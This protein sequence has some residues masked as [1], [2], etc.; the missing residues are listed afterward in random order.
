MLK[1]NVIANYFGQFWSA[2]MGMAFIPLY[3]KYLGIESYGLIGV[4]TMLTTWLSLLDMG[5]TPTLGREMA[6]FS[7]GA[8]NPKYLRNL[9]RSVEIISISVGIFVSI[10][11]ALSSNWIATSWL[12]S[13][14][15]PI[16]T[17]KS[18][19][20][21]MGIVSSLKFVEGIFK[22]C[23]VGLQRQVL[24][25]IIDASTSTIRGLGAV[26]ILSL[27]SPTI[28][29]FFIWQIIISILNV[30]ILS[31][32]TYSSIP[33]VNEPSRFSIEALKSIKKFAGGIVGGTFLTFFL[34]QIDKIL[35]SKLLSLQEFG[36]YTLAIGVGGATL[37][38]AS[39]ITQAWFP[40]MSQMHA[41]NN[42]K[43]LIE[44]FH[45]GSQI[46]TVLMGSI[47]FVIIFFSKTFLFVWTNNIE[48]SSKLSLILSIVVFGNLMSGLNSMPYTAQLSYG[49][50]SL[51]VNIKIFTV[52]VA[53]PLIYF[54]TLHF[55][56]I[57]ATIVWLLVSSSY[58]VI[59]AILMFKKIMI[60]EM[61]SWVIKDILIPISA[62]LVISFLLS[63]ILEFSKNRIT[64]LIILI[65][66]TSIVLFISTMSANL[67]RN[68]VLFF[69][70][71]KLIKV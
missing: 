51:S 20:V 67:L 15:L 57:G 16:G 48:L 70:K 53:L 13:Q 9:L 42:E 31:F 26:L 62:S 33:K 25:N 36:Y 64:G 37:I 50:T 24:F 66:S 55:G 41:E 58:L 21:I 3:I 60:T 12:K 2:L 35:L 39:P 45:F 34:T 61:W 7:A 8:T 17:I 23:I 54:S 4:F 19:I 1:K 32:Y 6:R 71:T 40:R 27:F 28:Q 29:A 10:G 47:S 68:K 52:I 30:A 18:S 65:F 46:I 14:N 59:S 63:I 69:F 22:S 5:L 43:K 44:S 49:W 38:F 11:I 56:T